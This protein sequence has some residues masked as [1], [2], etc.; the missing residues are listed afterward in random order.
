MRLQNI[1]VF[2]I[3][4]FALQLG[5]AVAEDRGRWDVEA[6][7]D[8]LC[9]DP[10]SFTAA[11]TKLECKSF[12]GLPEIKSIKADGDNFGATCGWM[13]YAYED[14]DCE[15]EEWLLQKRDCLRVGLGDLDSV[16]SFR[17]AETPCV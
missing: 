2:A 8:D 14:Y 13:L 3:S 15:G 5:N 7:E 17:V 6:Y 10:T 1:S 11:S 9:Q 16:K 12:D 4:A